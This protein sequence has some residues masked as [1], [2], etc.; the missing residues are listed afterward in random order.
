ME[1]IGIEMLRG[2]LESLS[3]RDLEKARRV[4]SADNEVDGLYGHVFRELILFMIEYPRTIAQA[5][6]LIWVAH[7]IERFADRATNICEQVAFS[8]TGQMMD[9]GASKLLIGE[10]RNEGNISC[11]TGQLLLIV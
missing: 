9:I 4:C 8:I 3:E 5:T 11:L 10:V 1:Q 7:N 2:S 6:R